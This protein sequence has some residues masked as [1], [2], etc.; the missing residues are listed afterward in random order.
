MPLRQ[1]SGK[2]RRM[3]LPNSLQKPRHIRLLLRGELGQLGLNFLDAHEEKTSQELEAVNPVVAQR[4]RGRPFG[5]A[6][7]G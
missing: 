5:A 2:F 1:L 7:W 4:E 6:R 3:S